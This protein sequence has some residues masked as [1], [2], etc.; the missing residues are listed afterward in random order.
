LDALT[1]RTVSGAGNKPL[2]QEKKERPNVGRS[3]RANFRSR[4]G[5][6]TAE[7]TLAAVAAAKSTAEAATRAFFAGLGF[8]DRQSA[9]VQFFAIEIGD[10]LGGLF[11]RAHLDE[12]KSTGFVR[13][14]VHDEF[15]TGDVTRLFE[16]VEEVAFTGIERE[17]AYE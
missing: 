6:P 9:T 2:L 1:V 7:L 12:R 5:L 14:L 16:Q 3:S 4:V 17:V 11:L 13:E 10:G 15:A 8:V